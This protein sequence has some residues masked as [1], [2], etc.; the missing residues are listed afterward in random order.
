[1]E[2]I[3]V[4]SSHSLFLKKLLEDVLQR[5]KGA[6]GERGKTW[7]PGNPTQHRWKVKGAL[8]VIAVQQA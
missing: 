1:M 3:K 8:K 6:N 7:G 4:V 2:G 5:N